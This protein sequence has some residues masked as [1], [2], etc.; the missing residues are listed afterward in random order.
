L[1][2][3][4]EIINE[5]VTFNLSASIALESDLLELTV[6][7]ATL[8]DDTN[9]VDEFVEMNIAKVTDVI[10]QRHIFDL[11]ENFRKDLLVGGIVFAGYMIGCQV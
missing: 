5:E 2:D 10:H 1:F 4:I 7:N 11:D 6:D 3:V 8:G 9:N